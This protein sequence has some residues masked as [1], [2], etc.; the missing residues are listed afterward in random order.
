MRTI[1]EIIALFN[2]LWVLVPTLRPSVL[3]AD[4]CPLC[5][6]DAFWGGW[7]A[8]RGDPE[9]RAQLLLAVCRIRVEDWLRIQIHMHDGA[10][11]GDK[12][13]VAAIAKGT[14]LSGAVEDQI[15]AAIRFAQ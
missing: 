8:T 13:R 9:V 15:G 3:D 1:P 6:Y 12:W 2:P 5:E 7:N 11:Q 4:N 10:Y 14:L